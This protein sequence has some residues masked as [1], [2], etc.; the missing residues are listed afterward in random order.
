MR[1]P[2]A[3]PSRFVSPGPRLMGILADLLGSRTG[4]VLS[5]VSII[6]EGYVL[7]LSGSDAVSCWNCRLARESGSLGVR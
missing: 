1:W 2:A 6:E 3:D 4:E 5:T 7:R